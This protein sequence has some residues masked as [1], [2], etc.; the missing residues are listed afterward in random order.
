MI[1]LSIIPNNV[2]D[3]EKQLPWYCCMLCLREHGIKG[4]NWD[5][6]GD[7]TVFYLDG[8]FKVYPISEIKEEE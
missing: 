5:Y 3:G 4:V 1:S 2:V 6:S 7:V 8:S